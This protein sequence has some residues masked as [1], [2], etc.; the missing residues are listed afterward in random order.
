MLYKLYRS[1]KLISKQYNNKNK[2]NYPN[3]AIG[4]GTCKAYNRRL[5]TK[6]AHCSFKKIPLQKE[7]FYIYC[8]YY[9]ERY[10]KKNNN[11]FS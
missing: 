8:P 6:E 10:N 5:L 1:K 7:T 11:R 9:E 3:Y 2:S 4:T